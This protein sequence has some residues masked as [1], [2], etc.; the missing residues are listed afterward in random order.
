MT[1]PSIYA[2][3]V[4]WKGTS[5]CMDFCCQKCGNS[6]HIDGEFV[7]TILCSQCDTVWKVGD[8]IKLTECDPQDTWYDN[9]T[10]VH[11]REGHRPNCSVGL[12]ADSVF[13]RRDQLIEDL[14]DVVRRFIIQCTIANPK[15]LKDA[16]SLLVRKP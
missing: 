14:Q 10:I 7:Y 8:E 5:V 13:Q 12:N 9:P 1:E 11:S 6:A 16:T 2:T 3:T 15:L 4:Q